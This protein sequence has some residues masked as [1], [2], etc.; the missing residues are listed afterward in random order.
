MLSKKM[1]DYDLAGYCLSRI[2]N[3]GAYLKDEATKGIAVE[4]L[5]KADK[6]EYFEKL[7][8]GEALRRWWV[9]TDMTMLGFAAANGSINIV[10][11]LLERTPEDKRPEV[12][13]LVDGATEDAIGDAGKT[14]LCWAAENGH[15][16][17][18]KYLVSQGADVKRKFKEGKE[19]KKGKYDKLMDPNIV[20]NDAILNYIKA[21]R[22][23][24]AVRERSWRWWPF[25]S[26]P[27]DAT[28][29]KVREWV[30]NGVV[31]D[32]YLG[33]GWCCLS[34]AV[35]LKDAGLVEFLV[36]KGA[37]VNPACPNNGHTALML[38]CEIGDTNLVAKLVSRRAR[39]DAK[40]YDD[41]TAFYYA[42]ENKQYDCFD[43]LRESPDGSKY[44]GEDI[45]DLVLS[46]Y[47]DVKRLRVAAKRGEASAADLNSLGE[48]YFNGIGVF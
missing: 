34:W 30:E 27:S 37:D 9:F 1:C 38:A 16:E 18:C 44:S 29:E 45:D 25:H 39:L 24:L 28:P 14:P 42:L 2:T 31:P 47:E 4:L 21:E 19:K 8:R 6:P 7:M 13:G 48:N 20:K 40:Q 33:G 17:V 5:I 35:E 3:T 10:K 36:D 41:R 43:I 11:W 46:K 15:L 26:F 23:R 22:E 12:D 32:A